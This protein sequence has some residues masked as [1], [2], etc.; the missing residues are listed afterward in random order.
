MNFKEKY[1]KWA[2]ITGASSGIGKAF[3]LELAKLGLNIVVAARRTEKLEEV[4]NKIENETQSEVL[5]VTLD[6]IDENAVEKLS[7]AVGGREIGLLINNAGFGSAGEF[8]K[9]S[10]ERDSDMIKLN[11]VVPNELTHKFVSQM[12][13]RKK[14]GI[15]FLGS[16]VAYQPTPFM[17]TYAATKVF[18]KMLGESLWYELKQ[19]NVDV[20]SLHPGGTET[21]F[22]QVAGADAGP[23]ARTAENVVRTALKAL[24]KKQSVIDGVPN[25]L[26]VFSEKFAPTKAVTYVSG[27]AMKKFYAKKK[28]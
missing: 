5:A 11:C 9:T 10:S 3:A 8:S 19:Y 18:N 20:L 22:Q 14:G 27:F 17:A 4:K 1:G 21:E 12:I 16:V 24:G 2:L 25:K 13:E 7:E 6:L 23:F 26:L 15:I 28:V